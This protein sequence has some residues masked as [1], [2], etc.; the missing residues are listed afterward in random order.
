MCKIK[1]NGGVM[2]INTRKIAAE[3]RLTH[4]SQIMKERSASG[5]TIKAYYE[6]NGIHPNVYH[7]WQRKIRAAAAVLASK[8]D[9][10][11]CKTTETS[12]TPQGWAE[13]TINPEAEK[14]GVIIIEIGKCSISVDVN[15]DMV[16]LADVSRILMT[17]C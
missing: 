12:L 17:L 13:I 8:A 7:Y 11:P 5:M 6:I 10:L 16:L 9:K 3:Y 1:L 4:W 14:S 15:T 2:V